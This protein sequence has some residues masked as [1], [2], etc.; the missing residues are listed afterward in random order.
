MQTPIF[1]RLP[2]LALLVLG[3]AGCAA[4][5]PAPDN[6]VA[7]AA[8]QQRWNPDAPI[9]QNNLLPNGLRPFRYF[10]W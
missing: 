9:Q 7:S 8:P 1:R 3:L 5:T 2:L 4:A 10:Y 6:T